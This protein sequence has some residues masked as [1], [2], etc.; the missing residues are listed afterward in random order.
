MWHTMV[1]TAPQSMHSGCSWSHVDL[2][3]RHALVLPC[4]QLFGLSSHA[5]RHGQRRCVVSCLQCGQRRG[6]VLAIALA[7][8]VAFAFD[9]AH[10]FTARHAVPFR[11]HLRRFFRMVWS[12]IQSVSHRSRVP[13]FAF[14][15]GIAKPPTRMEWGALV[16]AVSGCRE[17]P[18]LPM[19]HDYGLCARRERTRVASTHA[20]SFPSS[21][22][23]AASGHLALMQSHGHT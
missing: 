6:M 4:L 12:S 13:I 10:E 11:A 18:A 17:H 9:P 2:N 14:R 3:A 1:A 21:T 7:A 19:I 23:D 20:T 8:L 22:C 15:S 5:G 16:E